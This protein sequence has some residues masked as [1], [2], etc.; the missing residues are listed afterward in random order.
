V[1]ILAFR[2][3][4]TEKEEQFQALRKESNFLANLLIL[5]DEKPIRAC[6]GFDTVKR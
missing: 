2:K 5:L 6:F 3:A 1:I 4:S